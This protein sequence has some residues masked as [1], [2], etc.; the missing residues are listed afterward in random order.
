MKEFNGTKVC[1][2][3]KAVITLLLVCFFVSLAVTTVSAT[4]KDYDRGFKA[5]YDSGYKA[6]LEQCKQDQPVTDPH[7][8]IRGATVG[9]GSAPTISAPLPAP[10]ESDYDRGYAAGYSAGQKAGYN[11]CQA[12]PVADFSASPTSG[13][14]PLTVK[15][16][17][18]STEKPVKWNW[19]FGDGTSSIKQNPTHTYV[20]DGTYTVKLTVKN[21]TGSDTF[22]YYDYIIVNP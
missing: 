7:D 22:T 15:F 3:R 1:Q 16:T 14:V 2:I 9:S 13:Y 19:D 8:A 10:T 21:K 18:Q 17:D 11:A 20:S 12:Y 4:Q 6:G 5:G